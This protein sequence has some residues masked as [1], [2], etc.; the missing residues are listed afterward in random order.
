MEA[1]RS[2][3]TGKT[4]KTIKP[5]SRGTN[6]GQIDS[7]VGFWGLLAGKI[8]IQ[9]DGEDPKARGDRLEPIALARLSTELGIIVNCEPGMWL[10]DDNED[11][12][13]TPDGAEDAPVITWAAEVKA[14]DSAQHLK[15]VIAD[16]RARQRED[17]KPIDYVPNE[18]SHCYREQCVQYF[19]VNENLKTLY[20]VMFDDRIAIDDLAFHYITIKREDIAEEIEK[21]R[22]QQLIALAEVDKLI[23]ELTEV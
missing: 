13:I 7:A 14:L 5:L 20:F 10:S 19:V 1:R 12:A 23:A 8:A 17:Y 2:K 22:Q 6:K 15:Y 9:K 16:R 11:I 3:V 21:Q 18:Y 4:A